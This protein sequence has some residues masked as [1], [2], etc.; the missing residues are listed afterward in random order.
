MYSIGKVAELEGE[1]MTK[2][3]LVVD[4][5][6]DIVFILKSVL[7][8]KGYKVVEAFSGKEAI[9]KMTKEKPDLVILD[10]MMQDINGWE[11]CKKI[12]SDE[13]TKNTPVAMLSVLADARDKKRSVEYAGADVHMTKP[14][15]F[16]KL[17]S[18]VASLTERNN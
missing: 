10:I 15:E 6:E 7:S 13:K 2:A 5:E 11:V 4:D 9:E 8:K 3:V 1:F 18:M 17:L 16:D 14:I 12:K